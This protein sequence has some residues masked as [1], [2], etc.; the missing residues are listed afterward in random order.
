MSVEPVEAG[1][2]VYGRLAPPSAGSPAKGQLSLR[3]VIKNNEGQQVHVT[4]VLVSFVGA[5]AV[6]PATICAARK[7]IA[8]GRARAPPS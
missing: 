3:L 7:V 5:P 4:E 6:N 2:V 1:A 8:A